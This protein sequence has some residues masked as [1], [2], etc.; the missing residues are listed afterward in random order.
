M[1]KR[2]NSR[3]IENDAVNLVN[4]QVHPPHNMFLETYGDGLALIIK[5]IVKE[6]ISKDYLIF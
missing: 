3:N 5:K 4:Y 6:N 2:L 1:L